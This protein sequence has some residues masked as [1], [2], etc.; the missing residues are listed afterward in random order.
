M[1]ENTPIPNRP[2]PLRGPEQGAQRPSADPARGAAFR[3]LLDQLE[4]Q[5]HRLQDASGE[6]ERPEQLAGAVEQARESL[7]DALT[8]GDKLLEA[9]RAA[10]QQAE[11]GETEG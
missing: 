1:V 3:V 8:L 10:R 4:N 9:Y 11:N 6:V 7:A 5:A 2:E